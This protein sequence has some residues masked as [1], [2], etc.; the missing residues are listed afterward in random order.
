MNN[1]FKALQLS[2]RETALSIWIG[3]HVTLQIVML[4]WLLFLPFFA[5]FTVGYFFEL[6]MFG[7]L[8]SV[9]LTIILQVVW[10]RFL[11]LFD[12]KYKELE[13][14]GEQE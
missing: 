7:V 3:L 5:L 4:A 8:L 6:D 9:V 11:Y 12:E 1:F 13:N 2:A 14:K 10:A